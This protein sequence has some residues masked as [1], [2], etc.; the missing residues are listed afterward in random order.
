M[1]ASATINL[2]S[3]KVIQNTLTYWPKFKSSFAAKPTTNYEYSCYLVDTWK[4][5]H[6]P[7]KAK[8]YFNFLAENDLQENLEKNCLGIVSGSIT[9]CLFLRWKK[10]SRHC[11]CKKNWNHFFG[12]SDLTTYD[13][14]FVFAMIC[15]TK[16]NVDTNFISVQRLSHVYVP[17]VRWG[18]IMIQLCRLCRRE[19]RTNTWDRRWTEMKKCVDDNFFLY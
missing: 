12:L 8:N 9:H 16:K 13:D 6:L 1:S 10:K 14:L 15:S 11:N 7:Q 18:I 4:N 17:C 19:H 2:F 5:S 3:D